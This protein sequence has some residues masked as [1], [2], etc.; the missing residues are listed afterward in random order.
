MAN[1]DPTI[2]AVAPARSSERNASSEGSYPRLPPDSVATSRSKERIASFLTRMA[3][4]EQTYH[5]TAPD[6]DLERERAAQAE[7]S[8]AGCEDAPPPTNRA[9]RR[10]APRVSARMARDMRRPETSAKRRPRRARPSKSGTDKEMVVRRGERRRSKAAKADAKRA[11]AKIEWVL[12]HG[13]EGK[14]CEFIPNEIWGWVRAI[15][16][17]TTGATG[18]H[19]LRRCTNKILAG[20]IRRCAFIPSPCGTRD[21]YRWKHDRAR[22]TVAIGAL[23]WFLRKPIK[24]RRKRSAGRG[25][26][27]LSALGGGLP[28]GVDEEP[29]ARKKWGYIV[30]GFTRQMLLACLEPEE[31]DQKSLT[32]LTGVYGWGG[33]WNSRAHASWGN[34]D[35]W[36]PGCGILVALEQ[37]G[38]LY[39]DPWSEQKRATSSGYQ[40]NQYFLTSNTPEFGR[41]NEDTARRSAL[42]EGELDAEYEDI[43][44]ETPGIFDVHS[45][46]GPEP[47]ALEQL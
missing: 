31:D 13:L 22:D 45:K 30:E 12:E 28:T 10:R 21:K 17:D 40:P 37:C 44:W 4:S 20:A 16:L 27:S 19:F 43:L 42:F 1:T 18:R 34:N 29:P 11:A 3:G 38:V 2:T 15:K 23:L 8:A 5:G 9:D 26:A 35:G 24:T 25:M 6:P 46:G 36:G 7:L 33:R 14:P 32:Y 47:P 41:D 39:R